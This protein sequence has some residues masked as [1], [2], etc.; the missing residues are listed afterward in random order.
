M[1]GPEARTP[2]AGTRWLSVIVG[3]QRYD[4]VVDEHLLVSEVLALVQP[5]RELVALTMSG[6]TVPLDETVALAHLETGTMLLTA[7]VEL[8]VPTPR[9]RGSAGHDPERL[10]STE[11]ARPT[12]GG[13]AGPV[14]GTREA[15]VALGPPGGSSSRRRLRY[16]GSAA[17]GAGGPDD[18]TTGLETGPDPGLRTGP[19]SIRPTGRVAGGPSRRSRRSRRPGPTP[20]GGGRP[21]AAA[22]PAATVVSAAILAALAVAA[23]VLAPPVDVRWGEAVAVLLVLVGVVVAQAPS[24]ARLLH[25]SAPLLGIAGGAGATVLL[26][27]GPVVAIVGGCAGAALVALAGRS[28]SGADRHVPRVWL[29]F[30][31]GVGGLALVA[32]VAGLPLTVVAAVA[33]AGTVLLARVVPDL[34]IDVDDDVLIDIGR[35]SVTSWSPR[36]ARRPR[37]RGWRIDDEA[38]S[39]VVAAAG[40][41]QV[42]VLVGLGVVSLGSAA[43]LGV[44]LVRLGTSVLAVQLLLAAAALGLTLTA[45]AYRRRRDRTLLRLAALAPALALAVATLVR[46]RD[47]AGAS[48]AG[49]VVTVGVVVGTVLLGLAL[50][51]VAPALGRGYRSLWASRLADIGELLA[52]VSV[53]PLALWAAGLVELAMGLFA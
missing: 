5:R 1:A 28:R 38:V 48:S 6:E 2:G 26:R 33:L 22:R 31:G 25:L 42:A 47:G 13:G 3:P 29:A 10:P 15:L 27:E 40:V 34:V 46:G 32:L 21:A 53:L 30:G 18:G 24:S 50:L 39:S 9:L 23:T 52:L 20:R 12:G 19:L 49:V 45:R 36:E 8:D 41:E 7:P 51:G 37:R 11:G 17:E 35:L 44:T 4:V 16:A 14:A 43:V